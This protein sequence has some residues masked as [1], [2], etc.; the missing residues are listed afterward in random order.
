[1]SRRF[2][3][4]L[5]KAMSRPEFYPHPV[6]E[7][8]LKDTHISKVFLTGRRVYKVKKNVDLGFLDFSSLEKRQHYCDLEVA[9]NRRLTDNV[10]LNVLPVTRDGSRF[11]L[12]GPGEVVEYA[13]CMRQLPDAD[14]LAYLLIQNRVTADHIQSLALRL[15]AFYAHQDTITPEQ[16][17][18]SRDNIQYACEENFRK[19]KWALGNP[20]KS[21]QY[22][23]V[24]SATRSFLSCRK[25]LFTTRIDNQKIYDGHG[26]LRSG[27]IYFTG[28]GG[29]QIIDC[30]EFNT[31]FRHIDTASEIA[32]LAM[33][34]DVR[35]ASALGAT[36]VDTY[37][38]K[39]K[40]DQIYALLTFYK[41]Y[42]AMVRC[43]VNCIRLKDNRHCKNESIDLRR[44]AKH[45]L[46]LAHAYALHFGRPVIW[47]ICGLPGTGKS[48]LARAL[49][50]VL[51]ISILNSDIVRKQ[52]FGPTG[53]APVQTG[54]QEGIYTPAAH[55][56]TYREMVQMA[57]K[58]IKKGE[59][60]IL[61]ATFSLP[62]QRRKVLDLAADQKAR[63]VFVECTAPNQVIKTRLWKREGE[64]SVSDARRDH[65]ERFKQRYV[66]LV[67]IDKAL[68]M[69]VDTTQ[70]M[71]DS[72]HFVLSQDDAAALKIAGSV[73]QPQGWSKQMAP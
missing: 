51:E 27:H 26:D 28:K 58:V 5:F 56:L 45:Y 7:V 72:V 24:Q 62:E 12:S 23:A 16:A 50:H 54:F 71:D 43:K 37:T 1:M 22:Y 10:Y 35:K 20:L 19:T 53:Q 40:D 2:Q 32:F 3:E 21:D 48:S 13:V 36:L 44:K 31:G 64:P 69:Q 55:H 42:R 38:R 4:I 11:H 73:D 33:D 41:C 66:P 9:L 61:D 70:P 67:E 18:A 46:S 49:A 30:I 47:V 59:S 57:A 15:V 63:I 34:L 17:A 29:I 65:F 39:T 6:K 68:R 52:I 25:N 60:I 8:V 14:S